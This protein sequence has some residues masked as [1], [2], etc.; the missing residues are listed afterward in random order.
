VI[1]SKKEGKLKKE[2]KRKT[3]KKEGFCFGSWKTLPPYARRLSS[4]GRGPTRASF[5][6]SR[7]ATQVF[8]F[9]PR[10]TTRDTPPR[11]MKPARTRLFPSRFAPRTPP[12]KKQKGH[13]G[14]LRVSNSSLSD[15]PVNPFLSFLLLPPLVFFW[16]PFPATVVHV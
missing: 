9:F 6:L 7:G 15:L 12:Y 16:H 5:P 11:T 4:L 10:R 2:S 8:F 1:G 14:A 13:P 3:N